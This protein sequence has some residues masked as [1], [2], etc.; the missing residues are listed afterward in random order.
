MKQV[1][2]GVF[3]TNSSSTHS[4]V[5]CTQEEYEQFKADEMMYDSDEDRLVPYSS[6]LIETEGYR[7]K[8]YRRFGYNDLE[9]FY[10]TFITPSG[11]RMV[12]FGQYGYD[13]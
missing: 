1:R 8:S 9:S 13:G 3:E 7:Y 10:Q 4:L 6:L 11:D 12:A 5:I 2:C